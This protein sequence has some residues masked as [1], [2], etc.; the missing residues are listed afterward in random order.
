MELEVAL[1]MV[2]AGTMS[3][4]ELLDFARRSG[5]QYVWEAASQQLN[6]KGL[7]DTQLLELRAKTYNQNVWSV[8]DAVMKQ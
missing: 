6:L 2:K 4:D 7:T 1:G 8:I 3:N 5:D